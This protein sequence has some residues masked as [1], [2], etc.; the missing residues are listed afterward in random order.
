MPFKKQKTTTRTK[1]APRSMI[2]E[3]ASKKAKKLKIS[4]EQ[5]NEYI[6]T[7]AY[8]VWEEWGR[9][10]GKEEEIWEQAAKDIKSQ[11]GI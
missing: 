11:F 7:R 2:K 1:T 8:Y 10:Q 9:P 3:T 5:L 6:Q 4:A